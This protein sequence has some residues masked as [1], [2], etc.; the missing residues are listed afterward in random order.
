M[1][2]S[3]EG[4]VQLKL[5]KY[6]GCDASYLFRY[7]LT[8]MNEF[9]L[10]FI[11]LWMAPN[12]ISLVALL[13]QVAGYSLVA[14]YSPNLDQTLPR[15]VA[16]CEGMSLFI[17]QTL[18]NLDGKQARRTGSASPLGLLFD[19]GVDAVVSTLGA[20]SMAAVYQVGPSLWAMVFWMVTMCA[21][22]GATWEE[23]Y[24]NSLKLGRIN[25]PSDGIFICY[26]SCFLAAIRPGVWVDESFLG[27]PMLYIV[28]SF[29]IICLIFTLYANARAV[30]VKVQLRKGLLKLTPFFCFGAFGVLWA[31]C[32]PGKIFQ[33]HPR[34]FI[35]SLG[36]LYANVICKMMVAHLCQQ[37]FRSVRLVVIPVIL[38]SI[39]SAIAFFTGSAPY[40]PEYLMLVAVAIFHFGAWLF[41]VRQVITEMTAILGIKCFTIPSK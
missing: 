32:S 38:G 24:T 2:I 41:L 25:G 26:M 9:L 18:D 11:P 4:A 8:P 7:V 28:I 33:Q 35:V 17:Y 27:F 16:A 30:R 40:V 39:N 15:W 10:P 19:H 29:V 22:V 13:V 36:F 14:L 12:L 1:L 3:K 23:Y 34:T 31:V 21:F 20:V 6:N 5:Y 37:K